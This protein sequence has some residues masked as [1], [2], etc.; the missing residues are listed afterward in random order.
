MTLRVQKI[1]LKYFH[2]G[3]DGCLTI[4][5]AQREIPFPIRRVYYINKLQNRNAVRGKHAHKKLEQAI[6]CLQG[7]FRLELDN[8]RSCKKIMVRKS[9][10]GVYLPPRMW[11]T[12]TR[13]SQNCVILVLA[14]D[15]YKESD[16][17][18]DYGKFL[19]LMIQ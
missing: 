8:G 17:I 10:I 5:E 18:R 12:M 13:F 7:S 11:H 14:S 15:R 2:D 9:Y 3:V 19:Q 6:F 4:A 16:Y 1:K